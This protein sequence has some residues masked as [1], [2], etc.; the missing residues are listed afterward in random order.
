MTDRKVFYQMLRSDKDRSRVLTWWARLQQNK[1]VLTKLGLAEARLELPLGVRAELRRAHSVD[2]VV[3]TEGFRH[4]W[5]SMADEHM[6][7]WRM[8]AWATVAAV[9]AEVRGHDE[10]KPFA[11]ALGSQ[12]EQTGK[13]YVSELRFAQLQKSDGADTF[14]KRARRSVALIDKKTHVL[15]LADSILHWHWERQGNHVEKPQHRLAVRWAT[16]YFSALSE[17]QKA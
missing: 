16:D 12:K 7:E 13:P 15:S 5:F 17:Y 3:L 1:E 6:P 9:L 11:A 4:L 2:D 8:I 10:S 14:L